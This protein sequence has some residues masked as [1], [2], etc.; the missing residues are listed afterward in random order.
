MSNQWYASPGAA[1]NPRPSHGPPPLPPRNPG[2]SPAGIPYATPPPIP[3]RPPGFGYQ[4]IRGSKGLEGRSHVQAASLPTQNSLIVAAKQSVALG[5]DESHQ[6]LSAHPSPSSAQVQGFSDISHLFPDGQIPPPPPRPASK[7]V[8]ASYQSPLSTSKF[9]ASTSPAVSQPESFTQQQSTGPVITVTGDSQ[10]HTN[11]TK[12][13][14]ANTVSPGVNKNHHGEAYITEGGTH[15]ETTDDVAVMNQTFQTLQLENSEDARLPTRGG[16]NN[17]QYR[18]YS[19]Q[20]FSSPA[21]V[22]PE[23]VPLPTQQSPDAQPPVT[24]IPATSSNATGKETPAKECI[25]S[26]VTFAITWYTHHRAPEY[27]IC[28]NCYE[29]HI[30]GSRFEGEFQ[31]TFRDD[32]KPRA[33]GF[34][35]TRIK[36]SLW[37]LAFTSGSLDSLVEYLILRPSIP[38]C[39]GEGGV[40]GDAGIKWY[41]TRNND[42]PALVV[43]QA[44][45][46]DHI[47]A[48]PEFGREHFEPSTIQQAADQTWS[49]DLAVPYIYRDYKLR[50]QTNDWQSFVQSAPVRMSLRPCPG[51]KTE[52]PDGNGKK[53]FTPVNGP[54][55]LLI[56]AVCYCD[57][58][59]LTDQEGQWRDAGD[60][61]V[62]VF[63]VSV[64]CCF[65][66]QFNLKILAA[67]TLDT[68]DSALFWKA[69][70]I[71]ASEPTCEGQMQNATWYTLKSDPSGFE[72]CRSCHATMVESMGLSHH[73]MPKAGIS[74]DRSIMCSFNPAVSRFQ[75]YMQ[76]WL[77]VMYT[78]DPA[79]LEEFIKVYAFMPTCRRDYRVEN[80]SWFGWNECLICPEC[81]HE[82]IR[83]T[84]LAPATGTQATRVQGA[85]M[86]EMY[87]PRMRNLYLTACASDPPDLKPLLEY[88]VQRRAVWTQTMPRARQIISDI[89]LKS[90]QQS[91]AIS[92]SMF[93]S[94]SGNLWQNTLPLTQTTSFSATGSGLYNHMQIKGAEYGR[95]ASA[96]GA[97]ISGSPAF[98]A[99]ELERRWRAVE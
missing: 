93:Y 89:R 23:K 18:A 79:P 29:K 50:A 8:S 66:A 62:N 28:A 15:P 99:D 7:E 46:E 34:H 80:A 55:G 84:A 10:Q 58:I 30:Q 37:K 51:Q 86:C 97:E 96:I 44:C 77:E 57:Y 19:P 65:G 36:D 42:I 60:N 24:H 63:G 2:H 73:F 21:P 48:Y 94:F 81:H 69:V 54:Q 88:S 85:V 5:R 76:K 90:A 71:V 92:N 98:V 4:P 59:L 70:G 56:C 3:P 20:H 22:V 39:V 45:Y 78:Q 1:W 67:R 74:P 14:A 53:W 49:C 25:S 31:G 6:G 27:L 35:I 95:Q 26:N 17:N 61:L 9:E 11:I 83:G 72:I 91:M 75:L 32:G 64:S 68:N 82:F 41:R 12:K 16:G 52:Y 33:C 40:K 13:P 87:S 38:N 43:C 47:L